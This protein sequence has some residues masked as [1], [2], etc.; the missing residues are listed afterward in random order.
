[1]FSIG[2]ELTSLFLYS[3]YLLGEAEEKMLRSKRRLARAQ[4]TPEL[5][6]PKLN[7]KPVHIFVCSN[8]PFVEK[9]MH[10]LIFNV[11]FIS[12]LKLQLV[13]SHG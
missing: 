4:D 10:R 5:M 3:N 1:M 13:F 8:S 12:D 7:R 2:L 9:I 6:A 11:D